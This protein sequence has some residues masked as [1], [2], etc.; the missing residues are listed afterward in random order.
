MKKDVKVEF[1]TNFEEGELPLYQKVMRNLTLP[2]IEIHPKAFDDDGKVIPNHMSLWF[3]KGEVSYHNLHEVE[4]MITL[5][6]LSFGDE[7]EDYIYFERKSGGL[8]DNFHMAYIA[9]MVNGEKIQPHN[10]LRIRKFTKEM[11]GIKKEVEHP[12]VV[13]LLRENGQSY[14]ADQIER[15]RMK[16]M[17]KKEVWESPN[18]SSSSN[19]SIFPNENSSSNL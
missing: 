14:L 5:A 12:P 8:V 11:K 1:I 2:I 6:K 18:N 15:R 3:K 13:E 17:K 9:E 7:E 4:H 10:F 19:Y 16:K